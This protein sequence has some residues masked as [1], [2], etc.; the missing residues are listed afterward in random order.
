[1]NGNIHTPNRR[2]DRLQPLK[3]H[4]SLTS[5]L[6]FA[7]KTLQSSA[8]TLNLLLSTMLTTPLGANACSPPSSSEPQ[9]GEE[10]P[11]APGQVS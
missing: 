1:M 5:H 9:S 4:C 6:P 8:Y 3:L 7:S 11:C 2:L 10:A